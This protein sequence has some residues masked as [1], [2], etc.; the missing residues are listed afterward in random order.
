MVDDKLEKFLKSW[1]DGEL[2]PEQAADVAEYL[3]AN[4]NVAKDIEGRLRSNVIPAPQSG[5]KRQE[6]RVDE[7]REEDRGDSS[8][9]RPGVHA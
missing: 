5:E 6:G 3:K 4:P 9:K 7:K 2:E 8:M 1:I